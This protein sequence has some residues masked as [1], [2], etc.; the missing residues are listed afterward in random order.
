MCLICYYYIVVFYQMQ[1]N[2]ISTLFMGRRLPCCINISI[3]H[4]K[5]K[6]KSGDH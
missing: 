1:K 2:K 4:E 3:S 6:I 5:N